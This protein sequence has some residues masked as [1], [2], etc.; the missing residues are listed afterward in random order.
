MKLFLFASINFFQDPE[1]DFRD[2]LN[3]ATKES[4]FTFNNTFYIEV[5]GIAMGST[6]GPVLANIFLSHN[7]ENWL[8]KFPIE[9]KRNFYRRYFDVFVL[10]ASPECVHLFRTYMSSKHQHIKFSVE[11]EGIGL[12]SFRD[13]KICHK[14]DKICH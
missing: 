2:L 5:D 1:N 13:V 6:L 4:C 3:M 7:E 11:H 9:F 12:Y 8:N 10:F 14:K